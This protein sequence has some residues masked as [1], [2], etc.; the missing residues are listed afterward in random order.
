MTFILTINHG[1]VLLQ[2]F[3]ELVC[4]DAA[5]VKPDDV[6]GREER[7][8]DVVR[9]LRCKMATFWLSIGFGSGKPHSAAM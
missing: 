7:P 5:R 2:N 9:L 8:G 3:V 6:D 1:L 4:F